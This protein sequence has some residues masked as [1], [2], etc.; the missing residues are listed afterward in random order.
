MMATEKSPIPGEYQLV[1]YLLSSGSEFITVLFNPNNYSSYGYDVDFYFVNKTQAQ[2]ILGSVTS[3]AY[4]FGQTFM[5]SNQ[6]ELWAVPGWSRFDSYPYTNERIRRIVEIDDKNIRLIDANVN[7]V[8]IHQRTN[9]Y[10]TTLPWSNE[11]V[12]GVFC[13]VS[14]NVA[15]QKTIGMLYHLSLTGN[16]NVIYDLYP[17]RRKSDNKPG[18]YD[19]VNKVFYVNQGAGEFVVGPD[20]TWQ[21]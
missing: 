14:N 16:N 10:T 11:P 15:L 19:I 2:S 6:L 18:L 17:V 8:I 1:E 12:T 9:S 13:Y 3:Q 5:T 4:A 20:K 21:G 7:G